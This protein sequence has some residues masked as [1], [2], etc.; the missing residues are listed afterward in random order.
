[1]AFRAEEVHAR[2]VLEGELGVEFQHHD[3]GSKPRMPDLLSLDGNHVAELITTARKA[4]RQAQ[5]SLDPMQD[6]TLPDCV[7][8]L[9]PYT[10]AGA[11]RRPRATKSRQMSCGGQRRT[12]VSITGHHATNG[13]CSQA[14]IPT[15]SS[16]FGLTATGSV[17]CAFNDAVSIRTLRLIRSSVCRARSLAG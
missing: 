8:V 3:D 12:D 1:M 5:Q 6:A 4:V 17:S 13:S 14:W 2:I 16:A 15:R 11:A 10:I 9:L 7:R